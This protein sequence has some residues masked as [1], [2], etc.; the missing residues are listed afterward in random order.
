MSALPD[1]VRQMLAS[2]AHHLHHH[3]WHSVRNAW[4]SPELTP[5]VRERIIEAGWNPPDDRGALDA[6]GKP[7]LDN[8]SGEDFLYMHRQMIGE[9]NRALEEAGDPFYPRVMPWERIPGPG[10]AGFP[11]PAAWNVNDPSAKPEDNRDATIGQRRVKSSEFFE[12]TIRVWEQTFT[13]KATLRRLTLGQLGSLVEF[14]IHNTLHNRFASEP[15]GYRPDGKNPDDPIDSK[16]DVPDHDYLGDTYSSHVNPLFWFLHGW[17][18]TC[19]DLWFAANGATPSTYKWTGTCTGKLDSRSD[20]ERPLRAIFARPRGHEGAH[21]YH[22]HGTD[23]A[24]MEELIRAL[25][26]CGAIRNFYHDLLK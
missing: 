17:V 12:S 21:E 4:N 26:S 15:I 6:G 2:R 18:D 3:L 24:E 14:T 22:G 7:I 10:D 25:R 8:F 5:E 20:R 1:F 11:V 13:N 23:V 16:W 9:A 19:I